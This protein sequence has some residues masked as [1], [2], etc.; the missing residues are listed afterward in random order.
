MPKGTSLECEVPSSCSFLRIIGVSFL[1][2]GGS[3]LTPE[4]ASKALL[5]SAQASSICLAAP[6]RVVRILPVPTLVLFSSTSGTH[7]LVPEQSTSPAAPFKLGGSPAI[8][9][10]PSLMWVF[11]IASVAVSGVIPLQLVDLHMWFVQFAGDRIDMKT[12]AL[13]HNTARATQMRIP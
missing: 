4:G 5:S 10:T 6:P 3:K 2:A 7:R 9:D 11:L 1:L 12:T 13:W 8:F